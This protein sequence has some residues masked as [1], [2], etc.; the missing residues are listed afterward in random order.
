MVTDGRGRRGT[1]CVCVSVRVCVCV[2][3]L[4][5]CWAESGAVPRS[6]CAAASPCFQEKLHVL[7]WGDAT[8]VE[9]VHV[10][11]DAGNVG[12]IERK[13]CLI[14]IHTKA[15]D[16]GDWSDG[17]YKWCSIQSQKTKKSKENDLFFIFLHFFGVEHPWMRKKT[18]SRFKF[19]THPFV[20]WEYNNRHGI[21][22]KLM[23]S[24]RFMQV[25]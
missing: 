23:L 21:L 12:I 20:A 6:L 1:L 9:K 14:R 11:G 5:L 4:C 15:P 17:V 8:W 24:S 7:F 25:R 2:S 3:L 18:E 10:G 19:I 22:I 16:L 13:I